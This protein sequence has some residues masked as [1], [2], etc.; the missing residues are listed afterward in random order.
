MKV[1]E[2]DE[3]FI[4]FKKNIW[5]WTAVNRKTKKLVGFLVGDRSS[6]SFG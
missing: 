6:E 5:F 4:N 3:T 1:L 2:L